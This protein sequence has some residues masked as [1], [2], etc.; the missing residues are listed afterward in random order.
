MDS[1]VQSSTANHYEKIA[2]DG[3]V[4]RLNFARESNK[5]ILYNIEKILRNSYRETP[6]NQ[7]LR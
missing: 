3:C 1:N 2:I 6:E 5:N 4:V 7:R